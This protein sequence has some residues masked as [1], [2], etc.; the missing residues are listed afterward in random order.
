MEDRVVILIDGSNVFHGAK[1]V[2]KDF[3]V[4]FNKLVELLLRNRK[5]I[6]PYVFTAHPEPLAHKKK[7]FF[8]M[9]RSCGITVKSRPLRQVKGKQFEKGVDVALVTEMFK[10]A[11]R[12]V[13]DVLVLVSGDGDYSEAV[14][15][16]KDLG[17]RVE[18][19]S[20]KNSLSEEL[21][22]HADTLIMLDE[23]VHKLKFTPE[24]GRA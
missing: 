2:H 21:K 7:L 14:A 10:L 20:F 6:R 11:L 5:L 18:V 9:L 23:F 1:S 19:A 24:K 15:T 16:L 13:Y 4:D 8:D 17:I 3:L 12:N 22:Q